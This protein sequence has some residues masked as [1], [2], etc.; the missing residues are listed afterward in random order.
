MLMAVSQDEGWTLKRHVQTHKPACS[1]VILVIRWTIKLSHPFG[2]VSPSIVVANDGITPKLRIHIFHN[3]SN[4]MEDS[5]FQR[6]DHEFQGLLFQIQQSIND[7]KAPPTSYSDNLFQQAD[8]LIKQMALEARSVSDANLKQQ[9]L[10]KV[11]KNKSQVS[12]LQNE[13]QQQS[14][15]RTNHLNTDGEEHNNGHDRL[16]RQSKAT[17]DML[18]HQNDS[19]ERAR[20]TMQET[21]TVALEITE[22]LSNNREKLMSAHGRVRDVS[23]MTGRARRI[24]NNMSQRAVQQKMVM[25]GVSIGLVL[26]F[27]ILLYSVFMS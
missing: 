11:R 21:E 4:K 26:G 18:V 8:D 25:Y 6:Y 19:L 22:E 14:L 9:L 23:G 10:T 27:L 5:T 2:V 12:T 1:F 13:F 17:E 16:L 3:K 20:R 15:F 24:L 7:T